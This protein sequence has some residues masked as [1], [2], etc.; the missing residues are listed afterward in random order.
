LRG[1]PKKPLPLN[2]DVADL[3]I[4][5]AELTAYDEEH[6]VTY[7]RM[8]DANAEPWGGLFVWLHS[9]QMLAISLA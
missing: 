4:G 3:A 1:H 2:P 9:N 7:V 6:T 5:G 8:L